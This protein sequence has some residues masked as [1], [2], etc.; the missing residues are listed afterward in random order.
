MEKR[1]ILAIA[2]MI[3]VMVGW[4]IFFRPRPP[5]QTPEGE[6][7]ETPI[8]SAES[9][10]ETSTPTQRN[11]SSL[12]FSRAQ[13]SPR[14]HVQ[15]DNYEI[16]FVV[17]DAIVQEW[18]L[19]K[20]PD[21]SGSNE[22]INLIPERA[23]SCLLVDFPEELR[24]DALSAVWKADKKQVILTDRSQDTLTFKTQIGEKL[25][26]SKEFTFYQDR[27]YVDVELTFENISDQPL[28]GYELYWG[29]G[30]NADLLRHERKHSG[31]G[32]RPSRNEGAVAYIGRGKPS[33]DLSESEIT[34][35]V[36]WAGLNSKY[37]AALMI[38][39]PSD[40]SLNVQ[41]QR[42]KL[43]D[44]GENPSADIAASTDAA[45]LIISGF[46]AGKRRTDV[47]R[48]Y[49]GPKEDAILKKITH[50]DAPDVPLRMSKIIDFGFLW[51][52]AWA[53]LWL[54]H[55]FHRIIGNY[56]VSIILLTLLTK[57][58]AYPLIR[59][60]YKSMKEMQELQ[61]LLAELKEKYRDDPQ[62]LNRATMRLYK[63]HGVNPLGGCIPMIPQLP[64]LFALF[65]VFGNA[66]E[67]RGASFCLWMDDLSAPDT[68][69]SLPFTIPLILTQIDAIRFLPIIYGVTTLL[70][71]KMNAGVTPI[72][73]NTQAKIMQFVP[74]IFVFVLYNWA[75]GLILYWTCSNI[76]EIGRHYFTRLRESDET[77]SVRTLPSGKQSQLTKRK[78]QLQKRR[79]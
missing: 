16:A 59:K 40:P 38:P 71:Q 51:P 8:S 43:D 52:V 21:R 70:Q 27:Y 58:A 30:I 2:L 26:V 31:K 3:I 19:R 53:M 54:L 50:R 69:F 15:T 1:Y 49:V 11:E 77:E 57:L 9:T 65:T 33:Q 60:S 55:G 75:S 18:R 47:F 17:E 41:Y 13:E 25:K 45:R 34:A 12:Y 63:E 39:D 32:R 35:P 62:K 74:F 24:N 64:I 44:N 79:S 20:Y 76:F 4:T 42:K 78:S 56:G 29:P 6:K 7:K 5:E 14:V 73:D 61:P 22:S 66:V 36:L 46:S 68:L 10:L 23:Y 48:I 28:K 67:L 72:A 37:F